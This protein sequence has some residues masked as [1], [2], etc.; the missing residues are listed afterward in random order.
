MRNF[1][2]FDGDSVDFY[3]LAVSRKEDEDLRLRLTAI[4]DEIRAGYLLYDQHWEDSTLSVL[5]NNAFF[6]AFRNDLKGLY[7]YNSL[8]LRELRTNVQS[9]MPQA[10]RYTCQ[11]CTVTPAESLDHYIPKEEFPEYSIHA[12]NL[13]PCC[14][15][16]NGYKS[17]V[18]RGAQG[19]RLFLN[20]YRDF[21]LAGR[22]LFCE[23]IDDNGEIDFRFYI[24]NRIGIS[25][26]DF[27]MVETH[28][29][30]LRLPERMRMKAVGVISELETTIAL[31]SLSLE[32]VVEE[33]ERSANRN[34]QSYGANYWKSI[35]EL[36][37][38]SSPL[39]MQRFPG[40]QPNPV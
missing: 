27:A 16:C 31:S 5:H 28:F 32:E 24:E 40:Q 3:G 13:V 17:F 20:F 19:Q 2:A 18:W 12:N 25:Q 23:V 6:T 34:F 38:V 7:D 26:V 33:V 1:D 10:I 8:T 15:T 22:F 39:F 37:M 4:T 35:A 14:K 30:R 21:L 11:Y 36:A 29:S 9:R